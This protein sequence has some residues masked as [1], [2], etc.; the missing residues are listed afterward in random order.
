MAKP[1]FQ[2]EGLD[3]GIEIPA[4]PVS[5]PKV[6]ISWLRYRAQKPIHC[7]VCVAMVHLNWPNGTHAPNPAV[8]RRKENGIDTY[9]CAVHAEPKRD[10]DGVSR[11]KPK[12]KGRD[13]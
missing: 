12:K 3:L 6:G 11:A 1:G 4:P 2:E 8:Y 5:Q 7:D 10:K 9:W 13:V